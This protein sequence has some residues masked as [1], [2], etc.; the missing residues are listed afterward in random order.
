[1]ERAKL[2]FATNRNHIGDNRWNPRG[3]GEAF[4]SDG[5]ENLRFGEIEVPY[6]APTVDGFIEKKFKGNRVGDGNSLSSY[7][8]KSAKQASITAYKDVLTKG[9]KKKLP[10]VNSSDIF[11]SGLKEH[12]MDAK[13]VLIYIHGFNVS[14]NEAVG[15]ALSL[16]FMI[17]SFR[18]KDEKET[19]VVLFSWPSNGSMTPFLAYKSDRSDA[20][21]S[22]K[23]VGRAFLKLSDYLGTL[24][25]DAKNDKV[26]LCKSDINLLCHSMGNYLLQNGLEKKLIGY[27][28]GRVLPRIFNN[29]FLCAPDVNDDVF[30][31]GKGMSR[32]PEMAKNISIYY[33]NG[34]LAMNIS[35]YSKQFTDRLG[36]VGNARPALVHN[37]VHQIDCSP[38][39][40]GV[41]EHSYYLW[42]SVNNDIYQTITGLS[43]DDTKRNRKSLGQ[44]REWVMV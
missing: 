1:M 11:F 9:Y 7:L 25:E 33:N 6:D 26:K 27:N 31:E 2:Y 18:K 39:V 10:K 13:N 20:R 3:Y 28:A 19:L 5:H 17:N 40:H 23:A 15:S 42:A 32:L 4:S 22:G 43:F 38:I 14:W 34:D 36:Q 8:T 29:V 37:K 41:V 24:R 12:M 35:K 30:E 21:D 44:N 16:Q